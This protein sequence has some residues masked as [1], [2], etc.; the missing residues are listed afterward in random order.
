MKLHSRYNIAR[1]WLIFWCLFIGVGAVFGASCMLIKTDGSILQM[2]NLLPYFQ[3]L[4]FSEYLF[5]DYLFPGIALL[6]VNGI[7]NLV[8]AFMLFQKKR[9]GILLGTVF[10]VTLMLWICIQFIIFPMNFMSTIY[11]VFGLTQ[12]ITG[13]ATSIFYRQEKFYVNQSD[14]QNIGKNANELVVYFSRMGYTKKM[15]FECA[16]QSGAEVYE[17]KA[18]ERTEGTLGF[19]WCG[20]YGMHRWAMPIVEP[21]IDIS[22]YAKVT[23][24]SPIWVF[25]LAAPIRRFCEMNCGK[26]KNVDYILVHHQRSK[27]Q[28]ALDEMD[29]ILQ[30]KHENAKSIRVHVGNYEVVSDEAA[31]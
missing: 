25:H 27:Y 13:Y 30:L 10:G 26:I 7:P 29:R 21:S 11:F 28:N 8:A 20:R 18:T 31:C 22:T 14:Y 2:Q 23:I 4:P 24:C 17:I 15:A 3:V 12:F 1:K 5:E 9:A 16:N 19:W 6:C